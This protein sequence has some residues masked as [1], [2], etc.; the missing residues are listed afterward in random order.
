MIDKIRNKWVRRPLVALAGVLVVPLALVALVA[1]LAYAAISYTIDMHPAVGIMT[2][3]EAA[4][5]AMH[6]H[7]STVLR[8]W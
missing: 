5:A 2:A 6:D 7:L 1:D 4:G 3:V 8:A